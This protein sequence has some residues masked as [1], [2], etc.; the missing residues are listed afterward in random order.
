MSRE[1]GTRQNGYVSFTNPF[2]FPM[3][4][5]VLRMKNIGFDA[6]LAFGDAWTIWLAILQTVRITST[7]SKNWQ[8]QLRY[9]CGLSAGASHNSSNSYKSSVLCLLQLQLGLLSMSVKG[10]GL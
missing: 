6:L 5:R 4:S 1:L 3:F 10:V 8:G 7:A 9:G 2:E